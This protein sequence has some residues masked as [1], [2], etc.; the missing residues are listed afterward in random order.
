MKTRNML[1][2]TGVALG[3]GLGAANVQAAPILGSHVDSALFASSIG[4]T[5]GW[6]YLGQSTSAFTISGTAEIESRSSSYDDTFGFS[7]TNHNT[8]TQVFAT[9]AAVGTTATVAGYSPGYLLYFAAD[10]SDQGSF[11]DDN[12]Q[13]TDG[14]DS[15]NNPGEE[16]G[17]ID[18]FYNAALSKWALFFD[19]AGGGNGIGGD[20][21]D[22]NDLVVSFQSTVASVPEPTTL[23]LLGLSMLGLGMLRRRKNTKGELAA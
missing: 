19:D 5:S 14:F 11:S 15:G 12:R 20:D 1:I 7:T 4:S 3:F 8:R 22:Y 13:Y 6:T 16:Q 9:N 2:A 10:G 23:G 21:Q 17:D 18:I